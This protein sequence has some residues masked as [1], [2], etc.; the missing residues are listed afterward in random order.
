VPIKGK[1]TTSNKLAK[2]RR[3]SKRREKERDKSISKNLICCLPDEGRD[4]DEA[5]PGIDMVN[6]KLDE[7]EGKTAMETN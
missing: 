3:R 6:S 4:W 5:K 2:Q 7:L 1:R